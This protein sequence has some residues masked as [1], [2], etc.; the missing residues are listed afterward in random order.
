MSEAGNISDMPGV[1]V[2]HMA[3]AVWQLH[4][5][6]RSGNVLILPSSDDERRG[7]AVLSGIQG[8]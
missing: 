6:I 8:E 3:L 2:I 4:S 1:I 7:A 5:S